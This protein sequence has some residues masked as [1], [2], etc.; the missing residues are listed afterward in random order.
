MSAAVQVA[1]GY[2]PLAGAGLPGERIWIETGG[3]HVVPAVSA[4]LKSLLLSAVIELRPRKDARVVVLGVETGALP[5]KA[6]AALR[7][8]VA[9][10]PAGGGLIS[11]LNAWENITLPISYHEPKRARGLAS[12]VTTLL[13]QFG[14]VARTLLAKLPENMTPDERN[15]AGYVRMRLGRPRLVLAED[16][17]GAPGAPERRRAAAFAAAYLADCP[18]G[19]FVQLQEDALDG[20]A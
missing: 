7:A 10:L 12:Q 18:E 14:A 5:A 13:E 20:A 8:Q 15:L 2:E 3:S 19:T 9:F 4:S 11:N 6:R 16:P 1:L 17:G